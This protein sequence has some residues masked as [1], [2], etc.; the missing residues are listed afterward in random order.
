MHESWLIKKGEIFVYYRATIKT[1]GKKS[2]IEL[3]TAELM[4]EH[5]VDS[6][7]LS[8]NIKCK[9]IGKCDGDRHMS[10]NR[11]SIN[12]IHKYPNLDG[13]T[14]SARTVVKKEDETKGL[15]FLLEWIKKD[16]NSAMR[17]AK[18]EFNK[19]VKMAAAIHIAIE[20]PDAILAY[21]HATRSMFSKVEVDG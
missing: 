18:L 15:A 11:T 14:Y 21:K 2:T 7:Y 3:R 4:V 12:A 6:P 1:V 10:F 13:K 20:D 17:T 9:I 19:N 5:L 16:I 8:T